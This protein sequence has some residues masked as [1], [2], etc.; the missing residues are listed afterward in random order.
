MPAGT[1]ATGTVLLWTQAFVTLPTHISFSLPLLWRA[2]RMH[3]ASTSRAFFRMTLHTLSAGGVG[4]AKNQTRVQAGRAD[5]QGR[6]AG[7][8]AGRQAA[9]QAASKGW[10]ACKG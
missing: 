3:W 1:T 6:R 5:G 8:R 9:R 10:V 4:G 7:G 2:I